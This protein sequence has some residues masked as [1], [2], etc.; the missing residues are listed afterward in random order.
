[1]NIISDFKR[2][3]LYTTIVLIVDYTNFS[4]NIIHIMNLF[5]YSHTY[6][7]CKII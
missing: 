1:M 4:F 5:K 7:K 3:Y 2:S 6:T